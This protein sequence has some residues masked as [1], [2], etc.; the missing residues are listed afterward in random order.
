ML[1]ATNAVKPTRATVSGTVAAAV[2]A[3]ERTRE[4][5]ETE[6]MVVPPGMPAP[7]IVWPGKRRLVLES[8]ETVVLATVVVPVRVIGVDMPKVIAAF[9]ENRQ[10]SGTFGTR[11][12]A[13]YWM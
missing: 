2:A 13:V 7:A 9:G 10:S 1:L 6:T 11:R 8:A 4:A 12:E 3:A 5:P